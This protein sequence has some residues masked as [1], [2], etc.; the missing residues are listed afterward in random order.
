MTLRFR[1]R[2]TAKESQLRQCECGRTVSRSVSDG[3]ETLIHELPWCALFE[4]LVTAAT[5]EPA[6]ELHV[7]MVNATDQETMVIA[8]G[9]TVADVRDA[10]RRT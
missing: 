3:R 7:A 10:Q 5:S 9:D 4:Q 1:N 6:I 2:F 8:D